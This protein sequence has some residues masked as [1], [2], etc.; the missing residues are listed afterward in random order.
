MSPA[1][2]ITHTVCTDAPAPSSR[3]D[4]PPRQQQVQSLLKI[5]LESHPQAAPLPATP[6]SQTCAVNP[7]CCSSSQPH[8]SGPGAGQ[9]A[10]SQ[11]G[12]WDSTPWSE[13]SQGRSRQ[14]MK[15]CPTNGQPLGACP[16]DLLASQAVPSNTRPAPP[17]GWR[18]H[19]SQPA[20][21]RTISLV[22]P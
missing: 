10:C 9:R 3:M 2:P 15:A 21:M 6:K 8:R 22:T 14:P 1:P 7:V 13:G 5:K 18:F 11:W 20:I 12:R 4:H 19:R 16:T 17:Q